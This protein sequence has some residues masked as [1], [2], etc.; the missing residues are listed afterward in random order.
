MSQT[1]LLL[2]RFFS[3]IYCHVSACASEFEFGQQPTVRTVC[4]NCVIVHVSH[5]F[6]Q[7][8]K[9]IA[10]QKEAKGTITATM[11]M[12]VASCSEFQRK[13]RVDI[14]SP[15]MPPRILIKDAAKQPTSL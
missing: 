1:A 2:K 5:H 4:M 12:R 3:A 7:K 8:E 15:A 11:S 14:H 9:K 10:K 13:R 6:T